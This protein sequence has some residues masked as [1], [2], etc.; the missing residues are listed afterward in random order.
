MLACRCDALPLPPAANDSESLLAM[1]RGVNYLIF[2]PRDPGNSSLA[3]NLAT[4]EAGKVETVAL[5]KG[6][7][8]VEIKSSPARAKSVKR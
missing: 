1:L 8:I 4:M 3:R 2:D 7:V 5:Q 6:G